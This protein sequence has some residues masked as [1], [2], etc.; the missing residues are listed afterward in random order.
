MDYDVIVVGLGPDHNFTPGIVPGLESRVV[1]A[2]GFSGHGFKSIPVV[3]EVVADLVT[4]GGTAYDLNFLS[5]P[6][7]PR[8]P[9]LGLGPD[10]C[11]LSCENERPGRLGAVL[12]DLSVRNERSG[13]QAGRRMGMRRK[14]SA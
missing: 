12:C 13:G 9:E 2:A 3:G 5:P 1:L 4:T 11:D 7:W 6:A 10:V 14:R 8:R